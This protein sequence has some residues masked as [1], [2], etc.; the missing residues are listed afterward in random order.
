VDIRG[1]SLDRGH[2]MRVG[3]SKIAIFALAVAISFQSSY[4]RPKLLYLSM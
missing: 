3:S 4:M 1:G 2:Q